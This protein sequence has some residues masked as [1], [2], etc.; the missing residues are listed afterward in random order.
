MKTQIILILIFLM[1]ISLFSQSASAPDAGT[2][3]VENP[4]Q[5]SSLTNLYWIAAEDSVVPV[6]NRETRWSAHYIQLADIDAAETAGWFAGQ[7]WSP[8]GYHYAWNN[9]QPFC[10]TYNGQGYAIQ[11]LYINRPETKSLGLFGYADYPAVISN[12]GVTDVNITGEEKA[13]GLAGFITNNSSIENCYSTGWISGSQHVGGLVGI[14]TYSSLI[15]DCFSTCNV[16][17]NNWSTGGLIGSAADSE[18]L[19]CHTAGNIQG[20]N[21]SGGIIGEIYNSSLSNCFSTGSVTG[22]EMTGGLAGLCEHTQIDRSF[23]TGEINGSSMV[24]GLTGY[25]NDLSWLTGSYNSGNVNGNDMLGGLFGMDN[26]SAITNSYYNYEEVLLNNE[27]TITAGA[28]DAALYNDWQSNG[29]DLNINDY[30]AYDGQSYLIGSVNDFRKL[31]AFAQ[32][33]GYRFT[34][35]SNLDLAGE[36]GFYIP[37]FSGEFDGGGHIID[38]LHLDL[39]D[40]SQIGLFGNAYE[41]YICNLGVTNVNISGKNR[42]GALAGNTHN[43]LII[44][45]F[46]SGDVTG[47]GEYCGGL[48]GRSNCESEVIDCS[49]ACNVSGYDSVGGLAGANTGFSSLNSCFS[50]G[51][52][53]GSNQMTGGLAGYIWHSS[54][55]NSYSTGS[56]TGSEYV[57]GLTG[58]TGFSHI[59]YCYSANIVLGGQ[60]TGGLI[61][62]SDDECTIM[63]SYWDVEVS[64]QPFSAGGEDRTTEQM[65]WPYDMDTYQ[66]WDFEEIWAEDEEYSVNNGYPYLRNSILVPAIELTLPP[67]QAINL[68]I[69]PNPFNPATTIH[70]TL[71]DASSSAELLIFNLKGQI[72]KSFSL[73]PSTHESVGGRTQPLNSISWDGTDNENKPVSSGIYYCT[74]QQRGR[75]LATAKL[76]L[77]K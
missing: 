60:E 51:A 33:T 27:L 59:Y 3:S 41:A 53:Q 20:M 4:Y 12:L 29:L 11:H 69:Y 25:L 48:I 40:F 9:N 68:F 36:V 57:G 61:G 49:S 34:L 35:T 52:V 1:Q 42:T 14:I 46:S 32:Y 72:V 8:I 39:E 17:N 26:Y 76:A 13:G 63:D 54:V 43:A 37:F 66:N 7:G 6:P 5:I 23:N 77:I 15:I 67:F 31:L 10:G 73:N 70:F 24:G 65:T 74:L 19:N 22:S 50:R 30:L 55:M 75:V 64:E 2:G 62:F 44:S 38:N 28:L 21:C 47:T 56:V 45:C 71:P 18:I 16:T 58:W